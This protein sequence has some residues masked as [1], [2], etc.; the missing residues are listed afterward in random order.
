MVKRLIKRQSSKTY[1]NSNG[2]EKH[3]YNFFLEFENGKIVQIKPA[4]VQDTR[5]L[6]FF[7]EFVKSSDVNVPLDINEKKGK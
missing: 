1:T 3:Y 5:V 6:D 2:V 7:S 4:F